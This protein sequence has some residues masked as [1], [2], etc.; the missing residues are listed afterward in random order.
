MA[1]LWNSGC[2][3][4]VGIARFAGTAATGSVARRD[5]RFSAKRPRNR[6]VAEGAI[7]ALSR[8]DSML[9]VAQLVHLVARVTHRTAAQKIDGAIEA[10]AEALHATR[11]Q[12]LDFAVPSFGLTEVG[13]RACSDHAPSEGLRVAAQVPHQSTDTTRPL[14]RT[15]PTDCRAPKSRGATRPAA[16]ARCGAAGRNGAARQ[17][18]RG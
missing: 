7:H 1:G 17:T 5:S 16:P 11:E 8:L 3:G 15:V 18:P 14:S 12:L 10:K 4:W 13:R 2:V 9:A 6:P